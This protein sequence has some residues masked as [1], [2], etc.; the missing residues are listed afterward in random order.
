[1]WPQSGA[2]SAEGC[3]FP[4]PSATL[5]IPPASPVPGGIN[6][7]LLRQVRG[8][9]VELDPVGLPPDNDGKWSGQL[10]PASALLATNLDQTGQLGGRG[11]YRD[12]QQSDDGPHVH[13]DAYASAISEGRAHEFA[14]VLS[15]GRLRCVRLGRDLEW[16]SLRCG[17]CH[18]ISSSTPSVCYVFPN[19]ATIK[20]GET[21]RMS[22]IH[23]PFIS[24][25]RWRHNAEVI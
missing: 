5:F 6:Q 18:S 8:S 4:F 10:R 3:S 7:A 23:K 2:R 14:C 9:E 13:V 25:A 16:C 22:L 21:F 12:E 15:V 1:M 19:P 17:V 11:G 24:Y 20:Y